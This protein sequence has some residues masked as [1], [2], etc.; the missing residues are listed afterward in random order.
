MT[1]YP[2][3]LQ[4]SKQVHDEAEPVLYRENVFTARIF[5][6]YTAKLW[7]RGT[8]G[9]T[10]MPRSSSRKIRQFHLYVNT[11]DA[12]K[13]YDSPEYI[14]WYSMMMTSNAALVVNKLSLNR[15]KSLKLTINNF[16][17]KYANGVLL[18]A[19]DYQIK[20]KLPVCLLSSSFS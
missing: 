9:K 11:R 7:H 10:Q 18:L 12:F 19:G 8:A 16:I 14:G 15:L 3:I 6:S 5:S 13:I 4:V 2:A 1:L 17:K 20:E